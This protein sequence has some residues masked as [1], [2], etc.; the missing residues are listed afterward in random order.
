MHASATPRLRARRHELLGTF[1][2]LVALEATRLYGEHA[3][4]PDRARLQGLVYIAGFAELLAAWLL[5]E[6][7]L[8]ADELADDRQR[9][10]RRSE[11]APVTGGLRRRGR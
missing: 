2:D 3:W 10:V 9:P 6:I 5:D 4:P 11:P 8:T 7:E 1:A